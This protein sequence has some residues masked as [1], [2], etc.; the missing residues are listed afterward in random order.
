MDIVLGL[1][2][3]IAVLLFSSKK[4]KDT[5]TPPSPK[6]HEEDIWDETYDDADD[7]DEG[8]GDDN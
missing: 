6:D 5:L 4:P 7:A 3:V 8:D 1:I 2:L